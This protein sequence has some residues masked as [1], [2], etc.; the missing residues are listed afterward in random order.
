MSES[1]TP[2]VETT[3]ADQGEAGSIAAAGRKLRIIVLMNETLVPPES[4]EGLTAKAIAPF[5][6]EWDVLS[7]L[8][9]LGHEVTP[10]G[11]YDD[12][13]VISRAMTEHRPHIAFNLA[14]DF[15][16]NPLYDQH[17]VSYLELKKQ[18]YTGCNPRGLTL[19]HDKALTKKILSYHHVPMPGFVHFPRGRK[20]QAPRL[21]Y[22]LFVKSGVSEGSVGISQ[23]SLVRDFE[24]LVERVEFIHRQTS[25]DAITEEYIEGREIYVGVIG[26]QTL[27][28]YTPWELEMTN[29]SDGA[30]LIATDKLKWD[31]EYQ[32]KMG[33][34]TKPAELSPELAKRCDHLS[35]RIYHHLHLSGYA[36]LDYRLTSDG[37]L[38]LLEANP[39][40]QIAQGEDFADS[41]AHCGVSYPYLLQKIISLGLSY[42][43]Q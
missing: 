25:S 2:L 26:N 19:A 27:R 21:K 1:A 42:T 11:F 12:L 15:D 17:V 33:L 30:P 18:A 16:G 23:A 9:G 41:A 6:T 20:V 31:L 10:V 24:H 22:P 38:F 28:A 5:K 35:K 39:N 3:P 40:P 13:G 14:E 7:T 32:K 37:H 29:L 8:R 34:V 36:R 43:K 4:I